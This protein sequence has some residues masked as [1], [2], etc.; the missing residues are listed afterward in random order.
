MTAVIPSA[1]NAGTVTLASSSSS[2]AAYP[3]WANDSVVGRT[4]S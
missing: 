4:P 2:S 3:L 1:L